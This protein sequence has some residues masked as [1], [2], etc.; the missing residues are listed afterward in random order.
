[1]QGILIKINEG[2]WGGEVAQWSVDGISPAKHWG[3]VPSTHT[4]RLTTA[5]K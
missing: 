4:G 5:C 2:V 1:M 3:S